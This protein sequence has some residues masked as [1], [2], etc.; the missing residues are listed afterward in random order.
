MD[1][2]WMQI[3]TIDN[4]GDSILEVFSKND[5]STCHKCGKSA[6][7]CN[8]KAPSRLIRHLPIFAT[9]VYLRITPIRYTCEHCD[10]HPTTEP[11]A[12]RVAGICCAVFH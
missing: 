9:P 7:K 5:R 6:T 10:D 4:K 12:W 2:F 8:G 1:H 3:N 11:F